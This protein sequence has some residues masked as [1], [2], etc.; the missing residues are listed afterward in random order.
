MANHQQI[1]QSRAMAKF[2]Y[3]RAK[4]DI[5]Q[6]NVIVETCPEALREKCFEL[7]FAAVFNTPISASP[8][9]SIHAEH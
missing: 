1:P 6:I 3:K 8:H 4:E 7:L 2:D 9:S 5:A